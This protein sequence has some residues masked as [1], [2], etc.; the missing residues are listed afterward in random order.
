MGHACE[1]KRCCSSLDASCYRTYANAGVES[2]TCQRSCFEPAT[3]RP[4]KVLSPCA[5]PWRDCSAS[6]CC[7]SSTQRCFEKNRTFASC[8]SECSP[9]LPR[10]R[11]WS[12]VDRNGRSNEQAAAI[13]AYRTVPGGA[14]A[15]ASSPLRAHSAEAALRSIV[16][17]EL[18]IQGESMLGLSGKQLLTVLLTL[19]SALACA[20]LCVAWRLV[21]AA[22]ISAQRQRRLARV[23]RPRTKG[24]GRP[25]RLASED[26]DEDADDYDDDDEILE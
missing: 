1:I 19:A 2:Y 14:T 10:F 7:S 13:A 25:M 11:G 5:Q 22:C 16:G 18:A 17:D 26:A 24:G 8:M 6:G 15:R 9:E 12:C 21:R 23:A 20:S 3:G 4:C